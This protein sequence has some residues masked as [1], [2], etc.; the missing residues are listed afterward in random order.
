MLAL[1]TVV[2]VLDNLV[3]PA[4]GRFET[5]LIKNP[6]TAAAVADQLPLLQGASRLGDTDPSHAQQVRKKFVRKA[7]FV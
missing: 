7:E 3:T 2:H 4:R 1:Y 5:F 6:D